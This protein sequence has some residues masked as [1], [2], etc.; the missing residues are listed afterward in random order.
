MLDSAKRALQINKEEFLQNGEKARIAE[1][2]LRK[3]D[4][5]L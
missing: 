2:L 4:F 3:L 5:R 1:V